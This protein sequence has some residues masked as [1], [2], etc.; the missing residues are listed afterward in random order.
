MKIKLVFYNNETPKN[1][2]T[3]RCLALIRIESVYFKLEE[4]KYYPQVFLE[5]CK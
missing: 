3:Y 2:A 5:E 4:D 1:D